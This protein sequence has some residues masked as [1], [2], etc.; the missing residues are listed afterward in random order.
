MPKETWSKKEG[1]NL[2]W[3]KS[4]ILRQA[5]EKKEKDVPKVKAAQIHTGKDNYIRYKSDGSQC[6]K[7]LK[8]K[9]RRK[10]SK[11][12]D[13]PLKLRGKRL[14]KIEGM[15]YYVLTTNG[16]FSDAEADEIVNAYMICRERRNPK[17][18]PLQ[19]TVISSMRYESHT[20]VQN[21]LIFCDP[22][23]RRALAKRG[24]HLNNG[25]FSA[26]ESLTLM[27]N[28][29]KFLK[30]QGI[31]TDRE[32]IWGLL[33]DRF[34]AFYRQTKMFS[35]IGK[36]LNRTSYQL[37]V[38][39]FCMYHPFK[40]GQSDAETDAYIMARIPELAAAGEHKKYK[41]VGEEVD[42]YR[43]YVHDRHK[44]LIREESGFNRENRKKLRQ[45]IAEH[46]K[47]EVK[48][49]D[50]SDIPFAELAAKLCVDE[51]NLRA[52]W[53]REGRRLCDR[54]ALPI[55]RL[56]DSMA[57]LEAIET[58]EEEDENCINFQEIYARLFRGQVVDWEHHREH[59]NRVRR[60]VPFYMLEDLPSTLVAAKKE[61]RRKMAEREEKAEETEE[62]EDTFV[63]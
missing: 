13:L 49:I 27:K 7:K 38:R 45:L 25:P 60:V 51:D 63:E 46:Q 37:Y 33:H 20:S 36:N 34:Q 22:T 47:C 53:S 61:L 12:P 52:F 55:W 19:S 56:E 21:R 44:Q 18:H 50:V 62:D 54:A 59:Y 30:K 39:L 14:R 31:S 3:D 1:L 35:Y 17:H 57:L 2:K 6:H 41:I 11:L 24:F 4:K 42:R 15:L 43:L 32:T 58:Y 26:A 29:E 16:S 10:L 5:L 48:D 40:S 9:I 8:R 28:F 23:L